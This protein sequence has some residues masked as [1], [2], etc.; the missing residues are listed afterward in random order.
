MRFLSD[1]YLKCVVGSIHVHLS[2]CSY[3]YRCIYSKETLMNLKDAEGLSL[4]HFHHTV[5]FSNKPE[6]RKKK[7]SCPCKK[8]EDQDDDHCVPEV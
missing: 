4:I 7:S 2:R 6:T 1:L 8:E 3:G 5:D